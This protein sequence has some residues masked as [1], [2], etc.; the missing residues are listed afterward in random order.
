MPRRPSRP[1]RRAALGST[2]SS[3]LT[4]LDYGPM[5]TAAAYPTVE[6]ARQVSGVLRRRRAQT[7]IGTALFVVTLLVLYVQVLSPIWLSAKLVVGPVNVLAFAAGCLL[8]LPCA[9]ALPRS[10]SRPSSVVTWFVFLTVVV[11]TSTIPFFTLAVSGVRIRP[12]DYLRYLLVQNTAFVLMEVVV[13]WAP[14]GSRKRRPRLRPLEFRVLLGAMSAL[15]TGLIFIGFGANLVQLVNIAN[16]YGQRFRYAA[17]AS[18][19]GL[20]T[21]SLFLLAFAVTPLMMSLG[22]YYR[23]QLLIIGSLASAVLTFSITAFRLA[24]LMPIL[25]A[26]M[27]YVVRAARRRGPAVLI[28]ALLLVMAGGLFVRVATGSIQG[29]FLGT[30]RTIVTP[31][32]ITPFYIDYYSDHPRHHLAYSVLSSIESSPYD[33]VPPLVVGLAYYDEERMSANTQFWADGYA[34]FGYPGAVAMTALLMVVLLVLDRVSLGVASEITGTAA[35]VFASNLAN[36]ALL[37]A[38]GSLGFIAILMLLAVAPRPPEIPS[39]SR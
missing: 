36:G 33:R 17:A 39:V 29:L 8:L 3:L 38:L 34:N 15:L 12:S 9:L 28:V 19:N 18:S 27:F 22:L 25:A 1:G 24:L 11:P 10:F 14:I 32:T 5:S 26:A 6:R 4:A 37:T 16:P 21:Y 20:A 2:G 23:R 7:L 35:A 31:A 30:V 13:R